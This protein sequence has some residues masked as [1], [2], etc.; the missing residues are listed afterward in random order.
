MPSADTW[1]DTGT[2]LLIDTLD[3]LT[4]DALDGPCALPGWSRRHL[5]AHVASNA[6]A[7]ARL[8]CWARTGQESRMYASPE[9]RSADIESGATLPTAQL[10]AWVRRSARELSDDIA[11]LPPSA[12]SN[13]VVTAQGRTVPATQIVWLR[14]RE[15]WVHAVD[16]GTGLSFD[17]VPPAFCAALITDVARWRSARRDNPALALIA[18]DAG[19]SWRVSGVGRAR[20]VVLPMGELAAWLTGRAAYPQL[21]RLPRWL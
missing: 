12:W 16:L 5:L 1:L 10:R 11:T 14:T 4:D 20:R 3:R 18:T 8:M 13:L 2:G 17:D 6:E 19:R 15:A 21:P 9:Q 7:L